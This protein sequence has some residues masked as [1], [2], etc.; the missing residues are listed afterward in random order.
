MTS[1]AFSRRFLLA[2]LAGGFLFAQSTQAEVYELR[3]YVT[4]PG[5]LEALLKRFADHTC[6]LFEKHGMTNLG[7]WVPT[8][9]ADG[10]DNRLIYLI[11]HDSREAAKTNWAAFQADPQWQSA[12]KASEEGGKILQSVEAQFLEPS[13]FFPKLNREGGPAGRIF[14]LR[15]YRCN[16]GKLEALHQR[17]AN[18]T[19]AL[20]SKHGMAH[21][22]YWNPIAGERGHGEQ[23][24]Y[25]LAHPSRQAG[26]DA[27]KAFRADPQWIEAK[28][29]SE[30]DGSLTQ[31]KDGVKSIYLR[32]TDFSPLR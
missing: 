17:F 29:A 21:I 16:P 5:K 27:F 23:L 14:E 30:K 8:E 1:P 11:A 20:F 13:A 31:A 2:L 32:A 12:R 24:I 9:Q 4:H 7:Y 19:V 10:A 22:G 28:A 26:L 18:H 25:L 3:T 6:A 15:I